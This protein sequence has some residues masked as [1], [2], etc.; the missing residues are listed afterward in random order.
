M[1]FDNRLNFDDQDDFTFLEMVRD[2]QD[3]AEREFEEG[4]L[5]FL[6][7]SQESAEYSVREYERMEWILKG[8]WEDDLPADNSDFDDCD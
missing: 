3:R 8:G 1:S 5:C 2:E 7:E 6:Q 4:L